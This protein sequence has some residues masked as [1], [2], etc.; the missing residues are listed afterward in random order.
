MKY[1]SSHWGSYQFE[2]GGPL[3]PLASDPD[4]S[5]I[6][7]GWASASQDRQSRILRP[8][9]RRGWLEGDGGRNRCG[10]SYIEVSWERAIELAA[11][12]LG[13][14]IETH[15]NEA[16]FGGSYGWSSAGRFHHAQSQMRR[17]PKPPGGGGSARHTF[18]PSAA[19]GV[20]PP[21]LGV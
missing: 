4:P 7:R 19:P 12:A 16:V 9:V 18:F 8:A 21:L 13:K 10:D 3:T 6:G 2:P 15:G 5:R 11:G 14:V 1:T 17:V 20:L